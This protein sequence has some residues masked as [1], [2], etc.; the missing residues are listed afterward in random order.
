MSAVWRPRDTLTTMQPILTKDL[1]DALYASETRKVEVIDPVSKRVYL[2]VDA[3]LYRRAT[4][5]LRRQ[6]DDWTAI[7]QGIAQADRGE[8]IPFEEANRRIREDLGNTPHS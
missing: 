1:S 4:D 5:A 3:E 2:I 7:Q 6:E 8:A